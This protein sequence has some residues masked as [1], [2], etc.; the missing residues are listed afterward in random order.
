M[1]IQQQLKLQEMNKLKLLSIILLL[2]SSN[3]RMFSQNYCTTFSD[4]PDF[5]QGIPSDQYVS[6]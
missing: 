4:I 2:L 5:L 1:I 6:L 3:L